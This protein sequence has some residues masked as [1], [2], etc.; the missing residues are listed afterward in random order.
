MEELL[1][2][3]S[4]LKQ[5]EYVHV[6][7]NPLPLYGMIISGVLLLL[8]LIFKSKEV[9][10]AA[11]I[12]VT[13]IGLITWPAVEFGQGGYDRVLSMSN[14]EAQAWLKVHVNRAEKFQ[15]L[16][17][18]AAL[19]SLF[20]LVMVKKEKPIAKTLT[21]LT[22]IFTGLCAATGGWISHAGGQVRHSE[23]RDGAPPESSFLEH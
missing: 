13:G 19:F 15:Y 9:Q 10:M 20:T 6:L 3:F 12:L 17:Y 23:F 2:F 1:A 22:L 16:F 14:E 5:P 18:G 4:H 21:I 8:G 11:L 7:L